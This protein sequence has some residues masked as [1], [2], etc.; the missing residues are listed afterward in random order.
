M[1]KEEINRSIRFPWSGNNKNPERKNSNA[2]T[3]E[4]YLTCTIEPKSAIKVESLK[5]ELDE[6][7]IL[8]E[9]NI[10]Y[11][12]ISSHPNFKDKEWKKGTKLYRVYLFL[13]K[14]LVR[15]SGQN[16]HSINLQLKE[17]TIEISYPYNLNG[18][19]YIL[20]AANLWPIRTANKELY[21]ILCGSLRELL[22]MGLKCYF[23]DEYEDYVLEHFLE[24]KD[25]D[26]GMYDVSFEDIE[27]EY[28]SIEAVT[29]HD[30]IKS[31]KTR[32]IIKRINEFKP[33]NDNELALIVM[34]QEVFKLKNLSMP[35][36]CFYS[37]DYESIQDE[38]GILLENYCKVVWSHDT[39]VQ[40]EVN[41]WID[42][43]YN[44]CGGEDFTLGVKWKKDDY[45]KLSK[46][47]FPLRLTEVIVNLNQK[48][49]DYAAYI[50][51]VLPKESPDSISGGREKI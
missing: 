29:V 17:D 47:S 19:P 41:T 14:E 13:I 48:L 36:L 24:T 30:E 8:K 3:G 45:P 35:H 33:Q 16:I 25:D 27:K 4:S 23:E 50:K 43:A 34:C 21:D 1:Q 32:G 12:I 38:G 6:E 7:F 20:E 44:N 5:Q 49:E 10:I 31:A 40:T 42:D 26:E 39:I 15:L 11:N 2:N 51:Q 37:F 18:C 46:S 22:S 9:C 28:R